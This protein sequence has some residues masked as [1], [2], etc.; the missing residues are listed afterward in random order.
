MA[1]GSEFF[2]KGSVLIQFEWCWEKNGSTLE[3]RV[4]KNKQ[5]CFDDWCGNLSSL[6]FMPLPR[7]G[8]FCEI[9]QN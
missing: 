2:K 8:F 3:K 7:N 6:P 1:L 5:R 9:S 4:A